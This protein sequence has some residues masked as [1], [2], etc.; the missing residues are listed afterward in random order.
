MKICHTCHLELDESSFHKY[1]LSKDGL[2]RDCK[3]CR[4][5]YEKQH[6][7]VEHE[8]EYK[9]THIDRS[10]SQKL[11]LYYKNKDKYQA[12]M[13]ADYAKHKDKRLAKRKSDY[14]DDKH[15][16]KRQCS[17]AN[18]RR[19]D[20]VRGVVNCYGTNET[21]MTKTLFDGRCFICSSGH[22][23]T[24]DHHYPLDKGFGLSLNNAVLLCR[25]CNNHKY[26]RMPDKFYTIEQM[27]RLEYML[28]LVSADNLGWH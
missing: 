2:K 25:T 7:N 1:K 19:R 20:K 8:K 13:R 28:G 10:R 9:R 17:A 27:N 14:Y 16:L 11:R 18:K 6:R 4:N 3:S 21:A 5:I 26:N 22:N 23:L 24:I 15:P 12:F